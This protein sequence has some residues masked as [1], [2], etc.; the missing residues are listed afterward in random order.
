MI[1]L[2]DSDRLPGILRERM[3][4]IDVGAW[5]RRGRE[6]VHWEAV[7]TG[8]KYNL[9]DIAAA[10]GLAQLAKLPRLLA[11]R[12]ALDARY[13]EKL[14]DLAAVEPLAGPAA[15]ETAA[16]LFPVLLRPGALRIDRDALLR[17][18]LAENVG[19]GVHFR[20]LPLHRHFREAAG[21]VAETVP[22]AMDASA[23]V[24]SLP[25]FAGMSD[26][27]QDDVVK[28]LARIVHFF[29]A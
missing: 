14:R 10:L 26:A 19:V 20:A 3:H 24:L 6:Y 28:A 1:T 23:R 16:H 7:S 2:D 5:Q 27:D 18:L 12:R 4:G 21:A 17:A 11:R 8:W 13:R 15:A 9:S 22:V 29:R 25:L